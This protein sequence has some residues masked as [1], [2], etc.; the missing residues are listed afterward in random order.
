MEI[1]C[2]KCRF[3]FETTVRSGITEIACNCPRCGTP[4]TYT[5]GE[6]GGDRTDEGGSVSN[7]QFDNLQST[8]HNPSS[9]DASHQSPDGSSPISPHLEGS[10]EVSPNTPQQSPIG[11]VPPTRPR[12]IEPVRPHSHGCLRNCLLL[13][14]ALLIIA[15]LAVRNCY[16]DHSYTDD[17]EYMNA[18]DGAVENYEADTYHDNSAHIPGWLDGTWRAETDFGVVV[19]TIHGRY[20]V[21]LYDGETSRGTFA[22]QNGRLKCD[23]GDGRPSIIRVDSKHQRLIYGDQPMDKQ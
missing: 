8:I 17:R 3:R 21:E 16:F 1:K 10:G 12:G 5:F 13:F 4:F 7:L 6:E 23:F 14:F 20:I 2:P 9:P 15:V 22:Y 11:M 18:K 19:V